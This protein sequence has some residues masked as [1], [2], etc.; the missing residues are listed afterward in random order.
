MIPCELPNLTA[1]N[2]GLR[3]F[4]DCYNAMLLGND[5]QE[6]HQ[7]GPVSNRPLVLEFCRRWLPW[8]TG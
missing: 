4:I 5:R 2:G 7:D 3:S 1:L 6:L 8:P